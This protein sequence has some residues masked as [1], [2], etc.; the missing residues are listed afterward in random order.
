MPEVISSEQVKF[1][2]EQGYLPPVQVLAPE[3][4]AKYAASLAQCRSDFP[5][6]AKKLKT[7]AHLL[8]PWID[9]IARHSRILDLYADI[10]G[11]DILCY[12]MAMR[13]KPSDGKVQA[14]WHQDTAY[15]GI[16]PIM[17]IGALA[18]SEC[19]VKHGCLQVI[20]GSHKLGT[21][22]HVESDDPTSILARGQ[23]ISAEFDKSSAVDLVLKPG[24]IGLFNAATIHGSGV[25]TSGEDRVILLVELMPTC[26][27]QRKHRESAMLVRGTDTHGNYDAETGARTLFGEAELAHWSDK[28]FSRAKNVFAD[29]KLPV[30]ESYGGG[31]RTDAPAAATAAAK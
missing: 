22:P 16:E 5:E 23:F 31:T 8:C 10:L 9:E 7:K 6:H 21:L 26:V 14:G 20:P 25:N 24:E 3:E 13:I 29:S 27:K 4:V 19:T 12:S 1:F 30:S 15:G 18:L 2:D 17:I 11:D 28:V